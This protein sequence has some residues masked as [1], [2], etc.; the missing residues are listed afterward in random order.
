MDSTGSL[1][2]LHSP[3]HLSSSFVIYADPP[4]ELLPL[5]HPGVSSRCCSR[6]FV[7]QR[8]HRAGISWPGFLQ[9]PFCHPKGY[10]RLEAGYRSVLPQ[11]LCS[12]VSFP[13]GDGPV[14]PPIHPLW[15]LDDFSRPGVLNLGYVYPQ[16][17]VRRVLGYVT[18]FSKYFSFE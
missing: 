17:Y 14:S 6:R 16:G 11:S 3:L 1:G 10:G 15:R 5:L 8:C 7:V 12:A 18:G 2:R 9:S 13:H 4:S